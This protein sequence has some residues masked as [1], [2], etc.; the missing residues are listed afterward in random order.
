MLGW[1][2][3]PTHILGFVAVQALVALSNALLLNRLG[4]FPQTAAKPKVSLLVPARDEEESIGS[5]VTSLLAQDYGDLEVVV[6]DDGSQDRT[7]AVLAGLQFERLRVLEGRPLPDGWNGKAWA[8]QQLADSAQ[9]ELLLFTDA[10]TVFQPRT[11]RLAVNAME[12][13]GADLLTAVTGNRVPTLGEQLTVP[14]MS[15]SILSL[16][17]LAVTRLLPKSVAFTAANGKF[18]LFRRE[19]YRSVGG[20]AAVKDHATEDIAL[21]KSV[22]RQGYRWCLMDAT[23]LVSARM[24]CGL[25]DAVGGFSKNL[26]ALFNYRVLVALFVWTWLL[27]ITWYPIGLVAATIATGNAMPL[28]PVATLA[29]SAGIWLLASLRFGFPLHLFL[30]GPA[31][32]TVSAFTGIRAMVL[33]QTGHACWKGRRLVAR[34]PRL[35]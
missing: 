14:F 3:D 4:R 21:A 30:L 10:D 11:V 20:H 12:A 31:I 2:V 27:T 16:L 13:T 9:G 18:M 19:A 34:K 29:L 26:F 7:R 22:R 23:R 17:P 8:C 6:L 35:I 15:W 28:A 24:Y 1:L 33:S 32:V 25:M 5:C